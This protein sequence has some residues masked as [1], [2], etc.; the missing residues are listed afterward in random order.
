MAQF[1]L[2]REEFQRLNFVPKKR[3]WKSYA[4]WAV[5]LVALVA[6][7]AIGQYAFA[8]LW[9]LILAFFYFTL[10]RF[11]P[12][13]EAANLI[14]PFSLGPFHLELR[15]DSYTVR[16]GA[17]TLDLHT[18]ELSM[19]HDYG[20]YFRLD[21]SSGS[22]V[23]LPKQALTDEE[24]SIVLEYKARFPGLPEKRTPW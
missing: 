23:Y 7:I 12:K 10:F 18:N 22:S 4:A 13:L 17:S 20:D 24:R 3:T 2:T 5:A 8:I 1:S 14:S 15:P 21:H 11:T 6:G 9:A 16:A 19:V